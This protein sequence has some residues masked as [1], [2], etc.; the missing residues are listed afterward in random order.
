MITEEKAQIYNN[1][2]SFYDKIFFVLKPGHKKVG[3]YLKEHQIQEVLEVGVGTGLTFEHYSPGTKVLGVDM[4]RGML[5]GAQKKL[6]FFPELD[7]ELRQMD[8]QNMDLPD[9]SFECTYAPSLLTVVPEPKKLLS[10]MIRVTK[11]GGKIILVSHFQGNAFRDE[12]ATTLS[13][14]LTQ[15]LFG[16]RMDLSIGIFDEFQNIRLTHIE[17]VNPVG[18]FFLSHMVIIERTS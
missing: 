15:K 7:I 6:S 3:V 2:S 17:K 5:D 14:F 16:F 1:L 11:I 13:N 12:M 18:P 9:E 10:E 8:A 4:S